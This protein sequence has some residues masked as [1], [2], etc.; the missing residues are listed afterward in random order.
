ML[1]FRR[2]SGSTSRP[3]LLLLLLASLTIAN[4]CAA[5]NEQAPIG[6]EAIATID[7]SDLAVGQ[8]VLVRNITAHCGLTYLDQPING[9]YW[10]AVDA[11]AATVDWMPPGWE[12]F[13]DQFERIDL[14]VTLIEEDLLQASPDPD[15]SPS[16]YAPSQQK[17]GC[18]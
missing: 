1:K 12:P 15:I 9:L 3:R 6:E 7:Q 4:G 11:D 14:T 8:S 16:S 17:P 10:V 18:D 2:A 5:E 13:V